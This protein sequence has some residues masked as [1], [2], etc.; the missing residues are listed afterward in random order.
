MKTEKTII[1]SANP[2]FLMVLSMII[3]VMIALPTGVAGQTKAEEPYVAVEEMPTFPGGDA[4]LY[5]YIGKNLKYPPDA[6]ENKVQG[7]VTLKFCVMAD[8]NI[9]Q[10]TILKGV[11]AS[12]DKEAIRV[13]KTLPTFN[14]GK[15]GGVPVPVWYLLPIAFKLE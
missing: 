6:M 11:D 7:K 4:A 1:T 2:K 10:I 14:P 13:V 3:L 8:G 9:N 15:K 5:K 12:I